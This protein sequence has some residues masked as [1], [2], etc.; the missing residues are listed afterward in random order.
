MNDPDIQETVDTLRRIQIKTDLFTHGHVRETVLELLQLGLLEI[1][2]T[3]AEHLKETVDL[4]SGEVIPYERLPLL[5]PGQDTD[6]FRQAWFAARDAAPEDIRARMDALRSWLASIF[7]AR[8][9][10]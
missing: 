5:R 1:A 2:V 9:E 6:L 10:W 3:L 4:V 7:L 8:W